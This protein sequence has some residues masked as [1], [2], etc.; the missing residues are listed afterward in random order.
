MNLI[1]WTQ[2]LFFRFSLDSLP[3]HNGP[4]VGGLL[5]RQ[6]EQVI[7]MES[8]EGFQNIPTVEV[9]ANKAREERWHKIAE[10]VNLVI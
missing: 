3:C 8:Y 9:T 6:E 7:I 10:R 1:H 2:A 4:S 5:C